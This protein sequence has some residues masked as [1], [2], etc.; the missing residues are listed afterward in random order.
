MSI[1][2]SLKLHHFQAFLIWW[3]SPFKQLKE[4]SNKIFLYRF[5]IDWPLQV[6][7]NMTKKQFLFYQIRIVRIWNT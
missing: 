4:Q 2:S 1:S 3:H 6:P 7:R 5:F